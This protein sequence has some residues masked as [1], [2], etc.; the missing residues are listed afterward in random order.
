M[1]KKTSTA[2]A[3]YLGHIY[4]SFYYVIIKYCSKGKKLGE[5]FLLSSLF[6]HLSSFL[7]SREFRNE[8]Q[9]SSTSR[10]VRPINKSPHFSLH[11]SHVVLFGKFFFLGARSF[12]QQTH[13]FKREQV[14]LK[15]KMS[16]SVANFKNITTKCEIMTIN[17]MLWVHLFT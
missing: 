8:L 9:N 5:N 15:T 14:G 17:D 6:W 16:A 10:A 7:D 11:S 13:L 3:L 4:I 12:E 1:K 2:F